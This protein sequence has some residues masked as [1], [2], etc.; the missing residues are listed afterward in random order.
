MIYALNLDI[1]SRLFKPLL[2]S[3]K[4]L[5]IFSFFS[6][7]HWFSGLFCGW[8]IATISLSFAQK[9]QQPD[10]LVLG[11]AMEG[12]ATYNKIDSS[13]IALFSGDFYFQKNKPD[14]VNPDYLRA[15]I[16]GG[17][18]DSGKKQ[19]S[20]VFEYDRLMPTGQRFIRD[21]KIRQ[22]ASGQRTTIHA[23]FKSNRAD[24]VWTV[25]KTIVEDSKD[26]DSTFYSV[27]RFKNNRFSGTFLS[28]S[29]SLTITGKIDQQGFFDG[30]WIF[31]HQ[32]KAG[33][34][35]NE[36]RKFSSG[37]LE[38]HVIMAAGMA[39]EVNSFG[40]DNSFEGENEQW[41]EMEL[42]E[43]YFDIILQAALYDTNHVLESS[44]SY[45]LNK[46]NQFLKN[47]IRVYGFNHET[48]LWKI[49]IKDE[50]LALP[51]VKVRK[52]SYTPEEKEKIENAL[53][54]LAKSKKKVKDFLDNPQVEI[55]RHSIHE[56]AFYH[57][58]LKIFNDEI[59]KLK[60]VFVKLNSPTF[61]YLNREEI[62]PKLLE[63]LSFPDQ[64]NYS[65]NDSIRQVQFDFPTNLNQNDI[66]ILSLHELVVEIHNA[67]QKCYDEVNPIVQRNKTKAQLAQLEEKLVQTRDSV[68][69]V[70]SNKF[71]R[72]D[73]NSLHL[74]YQKQAIDQAEKIFVEYGKQDLNQRLTSINKALLDLE[75][76]MAFYVNLTEIKT[77]IVDIEERYTRVVWNPYTFTDMEE[78]V[79]ERLFVAYKNHLLEH[80]LQALERSISDVALSDKK[81]YFD[82]LFDKMKALREVDTKE[83]ERSLRRQTN[84]KIIAELL[85]LKLDL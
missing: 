23:F 56:I 9:S 35:V 82:A 61:E 64:L 2:P 5:R 57:A 66:H 17:K 81:S 72:D 76:F 22:T 47:S 45:L 12:V 32:T 36:Y 49:Q 7:S 48:P 44:D 29:D 67:V 4:T 79:K 68:I 80:L 69:T 26:I 58:T 77:E 20:W 15:I 40:L 1:D 50:N 73:F 78:T 28:W 27:A 39:Q 60:R 52:Y 34:F 8:F 51:K 30:E 71:K 42:D 13:G 21:L 75:S 70:F 33:D 3:L 46:S 74:R 62:L 63:K 65:F 41:L 84:P 54:L 11:N 85:E 83:L 16:Y 38:S 55:N 19:G 31:R 53:S 14:T 25:R 59:N 24:S 43:V 6:F 37:V 10:S 18:F